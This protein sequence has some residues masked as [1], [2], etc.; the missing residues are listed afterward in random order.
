MCD[1]LPLLTEMSI[2][3]RYRSPLLWTPDWF[4]RPSL[5]S[6]TPVPAVSGAT[7]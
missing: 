7:P 6:T 4:R 5:P 3:E 1:G 2:R